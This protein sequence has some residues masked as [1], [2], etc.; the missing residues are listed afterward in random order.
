M[1][2]IE[3]VT[4]RLADGADEVAFLE[5]DRRLQ[6]EFIPRH[7][8]FMRRTTARGSDGEWAVIILWGSAADADAS[9]ALGQ[10]HPIVREFDAMLDPGTVQRRCYETLD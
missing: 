9:A 6:T 8:G 3:I 4:F 7:R 10:D 1:A 5:T 2:V